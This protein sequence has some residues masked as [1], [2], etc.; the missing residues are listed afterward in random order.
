MKKNTILFFGLTFSLG[1]AQNGLYVNNETSIF[2][3]KNL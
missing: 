1:F 2:I 3:E